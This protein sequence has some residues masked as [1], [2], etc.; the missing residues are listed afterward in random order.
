MTIEEWLKAKKQDG[1]VSLPLYVDD[2]GNQCMQTHAYATRYGNSN[3][4]KMLDKLRA[5]E[6]NDYGVIQ[7]SSDTPIDPKT[8]TLDGSYIITPVSG[9]TPYDNQTGYFT[10]KAIGW[11][12]RVITVD[13][14]HNGTSWRIDCIEGVWSGWKLI[15][16]EVALWYGSV[17]NKDIIID[18][19]MPIDYFGEIIVN[20]S[21][22]WSYS[23]KVISSSYFI[24][25][26]TQYG[27]NNGASMINGQVCF[28]KISSNAK[29]IQLNAMPG[30]FTTTVSTNTIKFTEAAITAIYGRP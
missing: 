21:G 24:M 27:V 3:V 9:T 18:L 17:I 1:K 26:S 5:N 12:D 22:G 23:G 19:N 13:Y 15:A 4:E 30:Y 29:Q 8:L 20:N 10:V 6:L 2:N 25:A 11:R 16:G 28:H 14:R 7:M